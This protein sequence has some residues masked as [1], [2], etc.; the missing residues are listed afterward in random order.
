[1]AGAQVPNPLCGPRALKIL[2]ERAGVNASVSE[3][4]ELAG[5]GENGTSLLGLCTAARSKGL[6]LWAYETSLPGLR[7]TLAATGCPAIALLRR[8]HYVVVEAVSRDQ[9]WFL[10]PSRPSG[11]ARTLSSAEFAA[12]W[13]GYVVAVAQGAAARQEAGNQ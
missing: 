10:D 11:R 13:N 4:A 9:V 3:L 5:T 1:V 7:D 8:C 6:A 2:C 12:A